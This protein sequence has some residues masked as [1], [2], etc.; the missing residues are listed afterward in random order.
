MFNKTK[1][2]KDI[3]LLAEKYCCENK[4]NIHLQYLC[5]LGVDIVCVHGRQRKEGETGKDADNSVFLKHL[6]GCSGELKRE[7]NKAVKQEISQG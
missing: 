6:S 7:H 1:K 3:I 5:L 2:F 4:T